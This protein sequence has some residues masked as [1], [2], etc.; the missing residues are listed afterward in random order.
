LQLTHQIPG[1]RSTGKPWKKG[2]RALHF[3]VT[4]SSFDFMS[5]HF[6]VLRLAL[7]ATLSG[8][9]DVAVQ[10]K[11]S[12]FQVSPPLSKIAVSAQQQW[13]F[14]FNR[15]PRYLPVPVKYSPRLF[16]DNRFCVYKS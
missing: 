6:F 5:Q 14:L 11:S 7:K 16:T 9:L 2:F 1:D 8:V 4:V 10:A 3:Q 15:T 13:R 12:N